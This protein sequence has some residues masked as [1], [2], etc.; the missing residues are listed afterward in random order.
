MATTEHPAISTFDQAPDIDQGPALVRTVWVLISLSALVCAARLYIKVKIAKKIFWDDIFILLALVTGAMHA[1][2]ITASQH[3]GLGRH[4][5][6]IA[7]NPQNLSNTL[8][9]GFYTFVWA[10]L[11]PMAGRLSFCFFLLW[12]I[13][14]N[15]RIKRWPIYSA[16]VIQVVVNI[17][18]IV[19]MYAQCGTDLN[20]LW[21]LL[22]A[23]EVSTRCWD[24]RIQTWWGYFSGSI[25]SATDLFLT[26]LPAVVVS[27]SKLTWRSRIGLMAL[28]CLSFLAMI[29]CIKRT[30]EAKVLSEWAD[31]T[32]DLV[33]YAIW[34]SVEIN[35]V[36][37]ASSIPILRPLFKRH[38]LSSVMQRNVTERSDMETGSTL[39]PYT[40]SSKSPYG[41]TSSPFD[42]ARI[43]TH[44][45]SISSQEKIL[46]PR[47]EQF[48]ITRTVEVSVSHSPRDRNLVH[49]ALIGLPVD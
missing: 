48:T 17:A 30:V 34:V 4:M 16:M 5:Y 37:I 6:Y 43:H 44:T 46:P 31:Y 27:F 45:S 14:E 7:E 9:V 22:R 12:V 32:Y 10:F 25:N 36:I 1:V 38:G 3:Y 20:I 42:K 21:D 41:N 23:G 13:G 39:S 35:V 47:P 28:L 29:A 18:S 24:P 11:S 33:P 8:R 19:V 15:P 40:S 2:C 49:A 26:V